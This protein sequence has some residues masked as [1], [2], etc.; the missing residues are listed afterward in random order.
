VSMIDFANGISDNS[1][2]VAESIACETRLSWA[3]RARHVDGVVDSSAQSIERGICEG[4]ETT[5]LA[6]KH[7]LFFR[8]CFR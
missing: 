2:L 1:S 6:G 7:L 4:C 5:A 3:D 8:R